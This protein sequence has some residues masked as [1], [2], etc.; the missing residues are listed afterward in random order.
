MK[1]YF[2]ANHDD[3]VSGLEILQFFLHFITKVVLY[4]IFIL[5][6]LIFFLFIFVIIS[7]F[8]IISPATI[9]HHLNNG[10]WEFVF[11]V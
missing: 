9:P 1:E 10:F 8:C 6:I 5:L 7:S 4:V 11:W 2:D 3:V